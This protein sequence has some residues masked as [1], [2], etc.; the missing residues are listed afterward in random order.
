MKKLVLFIIYII[1]IPLFLYSQN[2]TIRE[3]ASSQHKFGDYRIDIR[4]SEE[5]FTIIYQHID[6]EMKTYSYSFDKNLTPSIEEITEENEI[7][8]I[9]KTNIRIK[10]SISD[11][12]NFGRPPKQ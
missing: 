2:L 1:I 6:D 5:N 4:K 9:L 3:I 10:N 11:F 8:S 12:G 7:K